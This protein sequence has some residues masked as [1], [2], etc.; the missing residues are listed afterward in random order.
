M[1]IVRETR[2][3]FEAPHVAEVLTLDA[4][5][6]F[7]RRW[8]Q[9]HYW[10]LGDAGLLGEDDHC[11]LI[12]GEIVIKTMRKGSAHELFKSR[13]IEWFVENRPRALA[14][15][16]EPTISLSEVDVVEPDIVLYPRHLPTRTLTGPELAL[17]IEV[18]DSSIP[19]D[20]RE[21]ARLY[22]RNAVAHYWVVDVS[23]RL[24]VAHGDSGPAGSLSVR[25]LP[26]CTALAVPTARVPDFRLADLDLPQHP[27]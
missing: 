17:V 11:E 4:L 16:S 22:A 9:A 24:L 14:V 23:R 7:D 19:S 26:A 5:G 18:A 13:L 25:R 27:A 8:T 21:K 6:A 2:A 20:T 15:G 3:E 1:S 12:D 10:R